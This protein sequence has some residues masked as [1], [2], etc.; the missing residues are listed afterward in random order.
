MSTWCTTRSVLALSSPIFLYPTSHSTRARAWPSLCVCQFLHFLW[1]WPT[2]NDV[3]DDM[4]LFCRTPIHAYRGVAWHATKQHKPSRKTG[5]Y[6]RN[7]SRYRDSTNA[8]TN[9]CQIKINHFRLG[10]RRAL[11]LSSLSSPTLPF[12]STSENICST[13]EIKPSMEFH[14]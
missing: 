10:F 14:K 8:Y 2:L 13:P 5:W 1:T 9:C 3:T 7:C 4:G 11:A 12:C 6:H